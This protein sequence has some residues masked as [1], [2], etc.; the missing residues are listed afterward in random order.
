M[1]FYSTFKSETRANT[2]E[3]EQHDLV[4]QEIETEIKL[5]LA[6]ENSSAQKVKAVSLKKLKRYILI[7]SGLQEGIF[8]HH[9]LL[10][11]SERLFSEAGNL[12]E[13]KRNRLLPKTVEKLLF[14]HYNL[15]KNNN[16]YFL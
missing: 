5:Y 4:Y 14:L 13:Q 8:R 2:K 15:K 9:H 10:F 1:S 3:S 11:F 6:E 12:Y 7:W 16:R